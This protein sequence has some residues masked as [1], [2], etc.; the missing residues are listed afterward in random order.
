M[1]TDGLA[2]SRLI[3]A[4]RPVNRPLIL[5]RHTLARSSVSC[6][7]G[8]AIISKAQTSSAMVESV[9]SASAATL[10]ALWHQGTNTAAAQRWI[11]LADY[12]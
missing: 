5:P 11:I 3:R 4:A 6:L 7:S 2:A 1:K 10:A 12:P 9:K 8:S